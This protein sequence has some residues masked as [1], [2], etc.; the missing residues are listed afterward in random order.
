VAPNASTARATLAVFKKNLN[1][2]QRNLPKGGQK[3]RSSRGGHEVLAGS[4]KTFR[5]PAMLKT[6]PLDCEAKAT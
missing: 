2:A 1:S 3:E 5:K 6:A 4:V